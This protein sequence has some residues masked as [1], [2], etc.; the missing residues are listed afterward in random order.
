MVQLPD[1]K[2]GMEVFIKHIDPAN[3]ILHVVPQATESIN[4]VQGNANPNAGK[5]IAMI[6]QQAFWFKATETG[7]WRAVQI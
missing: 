3:K 4:D 6:Y 7:D 5:Y 2:I 1:A